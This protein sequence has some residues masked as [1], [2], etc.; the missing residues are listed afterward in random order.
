[1]DTEELEAGGDAPIE[2]GRFFEIADT[3]GVERDP[4]VADEHL[5]GYLGV[6]RIGVIEQ[7]RRQQREAGVEE[8]PERDE[9]DAVAVESRWGWRVVDRLRH[10]F[11]VFVTGG[12]G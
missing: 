10:V 8:E 5:A 9:N 11:S 1:M 2:Q 7:R 3:V 12:M 4:V 6:D